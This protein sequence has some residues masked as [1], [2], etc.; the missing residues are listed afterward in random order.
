MPTLYRDPKGHS[1]VAEPRNAHQ[2]PDAPTG[3]ARVRI[4]GGATVETV[5]PLPP[6]ALRKDEWEKIGTAMKWTLDTEPSEYTEAGL[7]ERIRRFE[8]ELNERQVVDGDPK[9]GA[10]D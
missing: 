3:V 6:L 10:P 9:L 4:T 1:N 7:R 2:W 5:R 8:E